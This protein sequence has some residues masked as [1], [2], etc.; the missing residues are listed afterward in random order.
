MVFTFLLLILIYKHGRKLL[1]WDSV[2]S[3]NLPKYPFE[4][5]CYFCNKVNVSSVMEAFKPFFFR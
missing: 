2:M 3:S 5:L 4:E 1:V